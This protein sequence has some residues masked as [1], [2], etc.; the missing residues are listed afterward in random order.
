MG[1]DYSSIHVFAGAADPDAVRSR[2]TD[3]I[4]ESMPGRASVVDEA[5]RSIVVG[6]PERWLFVGDS[7]S[8][9]DD[10]D[11]DA[12]DSLVSE[13]ST[14]APTLAIE[15]SDSACVHLYLHHN[16]EL[17]DK[18]GTGK[19]PFFPFDS[20][21]EAMAFRGIEQ[22]WKP[23]TLNDDGPG[24]LRSVWNTKHNADGVVIATAKTLG[25]YPALAGCGF[26]IFDEAD[27]IY[28]RDWLEGDPILLKRFDEFHF[29]MPESGG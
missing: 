25:I 6:P 29:T 3:R 1:Y 24:Q 10:G 12:F 21:V 16:R 11:P 13:L 22:K 23:F 27:E 15:M 4:C 8:A 2:V 5:T 7:A 19:F 20:E 18:F 14:I 28:Y 17:I 9:T 26:T